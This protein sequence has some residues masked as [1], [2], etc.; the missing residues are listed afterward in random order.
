LRAANYNG[1]C[2]DEASKLGIDAAPLPR[3]TSH[4]GLSQLKSFEVVAKGQ[5]TVMIDGEFAHLEKVPPLLVTFAD[6]IFEM[7]PVASSVV[8]SANCLRAHRTIVGSADA[9]EPG[10][11][12]ST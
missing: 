5:L 10:V 4:P 6:A 9:V 3:T 8:P 7:G 2:N 12:G 11:G 1:R